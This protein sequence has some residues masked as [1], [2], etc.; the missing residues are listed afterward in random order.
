[1]ITASKSDERAFNI[2]LGLAFGIGFFLRMYLLSDQILLD[3]EWHSMSFVVGKS[4]PWILTHFAVYGGFT[5]IPL[6]LYE[7]MLLRTVGWSETLLQAPSVLLGLLLLLGGPLLAK[8]LVGPRRA[9]MLALLLAVSPL[10][11]FYSRLCRP[12]SAVA[13]LSFLAVLF[14]AAWMRSG[15][16]GS[17][18]GFAVCGVLAVYC[19][20][21]AAIAIGTLGASAVLLGVMRPRPAPGGGPS[22]RQALAVTIAMGLTG[23]VLLLPALANSLGNAFADVAQQGE[24]RMQSWLSLASLISGTANPVLAALF[25]CA[26]LTGAV[27]LCRSDPWLGGTLLALYPLQMLALMISRPHSCHVGILLARYTIALVPVSLLLVSYGIQ[28]AFDAAGARRSP[29]RALQILVVFVFVAA[30][31]V[32]GPL[33]QAYVAPNNFTNHGVFQHR[34][35]PIDWTRSF[36]SEFEPPEFPLRTVVR[37]DEVPAFYRSLREQ[38][39]PRP[40]VE[41]PM[42]IGD[43]FNVLY[44]YQ[45][46]HRR[47]VIAGYVRTATPSSPQISGGVGGDTYMDDVLNLARDPARLRF[48][49]LIRMDDLDGM[50]GRGVEFVIIHKRFEAQLSMVAPP[51]PEMDSLLTHCRQH[52]PL[53]YED[54]AIAVFSLP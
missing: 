43:H 12:Y 33:P 8:P 22:L 1:M 47:P 31:L 42:F 54:A 18:T 53:A 37:L 17:A 16:P 51:P 30:L 52:L 9:G 5:S 6:N 19:H 4:L 14:A 50:R 34:Y 48:R 13:C 35:G 21:F 24:I 3:D 36:A 40:I 49:N 7:W 25:W 2:L 15:S 23:A 41:Y 26:V 38:P 45:R 44:Y 28:A 27:A 29:S 46:V 10:L 11:I 20:P 32:A 39:G